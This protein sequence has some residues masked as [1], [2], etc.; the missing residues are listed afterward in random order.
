MQRP[1]DANYDKNRPHASFG[2]LARFIPKQALASLGSDHCPLFLQGDV[3]FDFY[4]GF[5]FEAHWIHLPGFL[6]TVQETWNKPVNTQDTLLRIHVKLLR[7]TKALKNLRHQCLSGWR[8]SWAILNITLANMEKAQEVRSLTPDE[9][10]FKSYLK[11]K[12][13]GIAAMQKAR[14]RQHSRLTWIHKGDTNTRFFKLHANIHRKK[15]FISSLIRETGPVISQENKLSLI[16]NHFS[17]I[18]GTPSTRS[19]AI[20]WNE[21]GYTHHDLEDLDAP[22]PT[23]I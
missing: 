16:H 21:L 8:I 14:A 1:I 7:T 12:A 20:N 23:K 4:R 11:L 17:S 9:I 19:K 2:K 18:M 15:S 10:E 6:E 5:R 13:L 22:S 3:T